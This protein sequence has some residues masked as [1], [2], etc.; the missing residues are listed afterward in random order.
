MSVQKGTDAPLIVGGLAWRS[1]NQQDVPFNVLIT[2]AQ[3]LAIR[4]T[5]VTILPAQGAGKIAVL[6][7]GLIVFNHTD[8]YTE[9]ADNLVIRYTDATGTAASVAI[10]STGFLTNAGDAAQIIY[11]VATPPILTEADELSNAPLL[12]HNTGDGE[13]GGGDAANTVRVIGMARVYTTML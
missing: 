5:P 2:N 13:L 7:G 3:M 10:E 8:V 11:P 9:S 1:K 4:A 6:L 12:L